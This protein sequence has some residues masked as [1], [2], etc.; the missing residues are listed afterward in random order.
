[1]NEDFGFG[2]TQETV[3]TTVNTEEK[4]DLDTG[5]VG[6][7]GKTNLDNNQTGE[8]TIVENKTGTNKGSSSTGGQEESVLSEGDSIELDGVTYTVNEAGDLV[9]EKGEVFKTKA[10]LPKFLEE[11]T[12]ENAN[13]VSEVNIAASTPTLIALV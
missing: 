11:Y 5:I 13:E 7:E 1:M 2:G 10:E 6:Q 9:D 3:E 4:T 8:E 12:T